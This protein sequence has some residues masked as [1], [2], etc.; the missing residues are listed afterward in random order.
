MQEAE[1]E[2]GGGGGEE[3]GLGKAAGA[4]PCGVRGHSKELGFCSGCEGKPVGALTPMGDVISAE[5]LR[6]VVVLGGEQTHSG[7]GRPVRGLLFPSH[8][9]GPLGAGLTLIVLGLTL[10]CSTSGRLEA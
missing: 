6:P 5:C 8:C 4:R 10:A 9:P 1:K 3:T 2:R 7:C